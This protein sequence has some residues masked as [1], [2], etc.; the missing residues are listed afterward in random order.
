MTEYKLGNVV[1]RYPKNT[2]CHRLFV[3]RDC[4][5][6]SSEN[7]ATSHLSLIETTVCKTIKDV[8][9]EKFLATRSAQDEFIFGD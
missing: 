7:L 4:L 6:R 9:L 3:H 1:L 2:K 8:N 5:V